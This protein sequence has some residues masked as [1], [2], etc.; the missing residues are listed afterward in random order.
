M[1]LSGTG[2]LIGLFALM[3]VGWCDTDFDVITIRGLGRLTVCLTQNGFSYPAVKICPGLLQLGCEAIGQGPCLALGEQAGTALV[4]VCAPS[5]LGCD[6]ALAEELFRHFPTPTPTTLQGLPGSLLQRP[7]EQ[8]LPFGL[9]ELRSKVKSQR[10]TPELPCGA[11]E[12]LCFGA[13]VPASGTVVCLG[14]HLRSECPGQ[15]LF[16]REEVTGIGDELS[17]ASELGC[18]AAI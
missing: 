8:R 13:P 18:R 12:V 17:E 10:S 1:E 7:W 3:L 2:S 14:C 5:P 9:G 16:S 4:H 11:P 15:A 6:V